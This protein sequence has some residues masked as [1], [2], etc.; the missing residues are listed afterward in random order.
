MTVKFFKVTGSGWKTPLYYAGYTVQAVK[1]TASADC[2]SQ[3]I[4]HCREIPLEDIPPNEQFVY[5]V[6][7]EYEDAHWVANLRSPDI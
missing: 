2:N 5:N 6:N 3:F 7:L 1:E 4:P